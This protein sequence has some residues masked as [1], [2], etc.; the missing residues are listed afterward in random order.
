MKRNLHLIKASTAIAKNKPR[1]TKQNRK[2]HLSYAQS[3]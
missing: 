1:K 2:Q 3:A